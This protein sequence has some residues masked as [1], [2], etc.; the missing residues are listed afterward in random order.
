M[1]RIIKRMGMIVF[2]V[3]MLIGLIQRNL[4]ASDDDAYAITGLLALGSLVIVVIGYSAEIWSGSAE[5]W[6]GQVKLRPFQSFRMGANLFLFIVGLRIVVGL[7][8]PGLTT[9]W[10][11]ALIQSAV[12]AMTYSLYSTAYRRPA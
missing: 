12:W 3:S 5:I 1:S 11:L 8:F 6:S 7:V 2:A 10:T 9:D 4:L